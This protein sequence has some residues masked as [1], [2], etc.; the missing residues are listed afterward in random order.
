MVTPHAPS[1]PNGSSPRRDVARKEAA[2]TYAGYGWPVLPG[3]DWNG[4]TWQV[5]SPGGKRTDGA[6]P[7]LPRNVATVDPDTIAGWWHG[8][9]GVGELSP[10]VLL[11][12]GPFSFNVI[13]VSTAVGE[14]A[15]QHQQFVA[16]PTPVAYRPDTEREY[17]LTKPIGEPSGRNIDPEV[18]DMVTVMQTGS[19]ILVPPATV[20][21]GREVEWRVDPATLDGGLADF[22]TTAGSL[23]FA[24]YNLKNSQ[25]QG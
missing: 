5:A 15:R 13:S 19:W 7:I 3:S 16:A 20:S 12:S 8:R 1:P 22:I 14:R 2:L 25:D 23:L 10:T 24:A 4:R 18:A 17:F 9:A 6:Q 21:A 11:R